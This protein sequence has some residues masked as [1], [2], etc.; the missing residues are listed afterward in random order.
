MAYLRVRPRGA[1]QFTLDRAADAIGPVVIDQSANG[2]VAWLHKTSSGDND[3]FCKFA[4]G[5]RVL[6]SDHAA[7]VAATGLLDQHSVPG[8]GPREDRPPGGVG[9]RP[10]AMVFWESTN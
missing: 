1:D 7:R 8:P 3:M 9:L 2:Y 6:T 4:A 5:A 10:E